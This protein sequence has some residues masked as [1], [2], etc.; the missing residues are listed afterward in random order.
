MS[1]FTKLFAEINVAAVT[2]EQAFDKVTNKPVGDKKTPDGKQV[3]GLHIPVKTKVKRGDQELEELNY[4]KLNS[5][6]ELSPGQHTVELEMFEF[7]DGKISFR[8]TAVVNPSSAR[9]V[10]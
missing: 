2:K 3:Y 6:V 8:A 9:K 7:K 5:L 1:K 4:E 10:V